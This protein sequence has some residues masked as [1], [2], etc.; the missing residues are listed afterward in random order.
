M[1]FFFFFEYYRSLHLEYIYYLFAKGFI[2]STVVE[3]NTRLISCFWHNLLNIN[4]EESQKKTV[5]LEMG[6]ARL[7]LCCMHALLEH[8]CL[9]RLHN[10]TLNFPAWS[11][12]KDWGAGAPDWDPV[13]GGEWVTTRKDDIRAL[14]DWLSRG[15]WLFMIIF[16]ICLYFSDLTK[17]L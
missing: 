9:W 6:F 11:H 8:Y 1:L 4:V 10:K 14:G 17:F 12:C 7:T 13:S 3:R 15:R 2:S 5:Y 16:I